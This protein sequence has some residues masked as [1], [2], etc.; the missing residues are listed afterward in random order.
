MAPVISRKNPLPLS[1]SHGR[2]S[3]LRRFCCENGANVFPLHRKSAV[4]TYHPAFI[5]ILLTCLAHPSSPETQLPL[6][7]QFQRLIIRIHFIL[8]PLSLHWEV[9]QL[10]ILLRLSNTCQRRR[11][12]S[13]WY[14]D[15]PWLPLSPH[16]LSALLLRIT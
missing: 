11:R 4:S 13:Q 16:P 10:D 1:L 15:L 3:R 9:T 2:V 12:S 5:S 6:L 8:D 7:E 14:L